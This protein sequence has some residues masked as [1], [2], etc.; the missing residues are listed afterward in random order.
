M[1]QPLGYRRDWKSFLINPGFQL[2]VVGASFFTAV[3]VIGIFYSNILYMFWKFKQQGLERGL[4][5]ND[6]Y[7]LF[8]GEQVSTMN[9]I[10]FVTTLVTLAVIIVAG[11]VLSHRVAGPIHR[12]VRH[13]HALRTGTTKYPLKFRD[14][15]FFPELA[16][17]LNS[18]LGFSSSGVSMRS[19]PEPKTERT[20]RPQRPERAE[21]DS[22]EGRRPRTGRSRRSGR[23]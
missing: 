5:E 13:L 8:I 3:L 23:R 16:D 22:E 4:P 19:R 9:A 6:V 20:E 17:E 18:Y 21:R 1:S 12:A 15:D 2:W 14:G 10:F 11:L 7:F